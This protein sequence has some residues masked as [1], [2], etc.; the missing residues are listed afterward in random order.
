MLRTACLMVGVPTEFGAGGNGRTIRDLVE[1]LDT[2]VG[3]PMG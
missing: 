1:A 3:V 2:A